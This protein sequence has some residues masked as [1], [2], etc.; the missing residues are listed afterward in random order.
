VKRLPVPAGGHVWEH[1]PLALEVDA[2]RVPDWNFDLATRRPGPKLPEQPL[3]LAE[4][5]EK[6]QLLPYGF[7]TLRLTYLPVVKTAARHA[8]PETAVGKGLGRAKP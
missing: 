4:R 2:Q 8:G 7:T 3:K 6:V 1:S 5:V